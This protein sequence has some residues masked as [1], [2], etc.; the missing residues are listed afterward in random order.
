MFVRG[1]TMEISAETSTELTQLFEE[2]LSGGLR[3]AR[4][5][6]APAR[7]AHPIRAR[8]RDRATNSC[9]V[10]APAR[11]EVEGVTGG[12]WNSGGRARSRPLD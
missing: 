12:G 2:I 6:T 10:A 3:P 1:G 5:L 11:G 9:A 4:R 7:M 8:D